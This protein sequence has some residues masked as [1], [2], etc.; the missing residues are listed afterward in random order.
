RE[1]SQAMSK[2]ATLPKFYLGMWAAYP[3]LVPFYLLGKTPVPGQQK[4]EGGVPQASDYYLVGLMA[5]V[6]AGLP[7]RLSR[8]ALLVARAFSCFVCYTALVNMVWSTALEDLSLLKSTLYYAYD[9]MLFLTCLMLYSAFK[10]GFLKVTVYSVGASVML[11][12]FLSPLA[13]E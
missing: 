10:D 12:A 5:L 2:T 1:R 3:L 9:G 4:V 6:L 8:H 13:P 7:L 11:Q